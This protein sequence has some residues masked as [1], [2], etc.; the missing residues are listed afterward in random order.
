[1]A[2]EILHIENLHKAFGKLEVL[3][4]IDFSVNK[5]EVIVIV[6]RSGSGKSTL[7]RC[8]NLIEVP[9]SGCLRF[10]HQAF[11]REFHFGDGKHRVSGAELQELRTHIGMVFQHFN[12]W[13]HLTAL[14]NVTLAL[15]K[16]V[17]MS[18]NEANERGMRQLEKV[19]LADKG[20]AHPG[21][22]SGGMQ[23]RVAI[24][25]ALALDPAIMLFDE[26]TSA[27]DPELVAG[28]LE[29]MRRL[30]EEGMT[31]LVVTHEM[32][33][34]QEVGDRVVFMDGGVIVE[35]GPARQ[36]VNDPQNPKTREFLKVI[37][38]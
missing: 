13:P 34:A 24:A 9:D 23:Q 32:G 31:M 2:E 12:L 15:K 16:V 5:G 1:M 36:M 30:A 11:E 14:E 4:G 7:L 8:T 25:R 22:L 28:I 6:G 17:G 26:V 38:H 3:K 19:G 29:E 33:F 27:L 37:L 20:S 18:A 10:R 21:T 35:Q